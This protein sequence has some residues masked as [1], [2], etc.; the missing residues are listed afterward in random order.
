[1]TTCSNNGTLLAGSPY[2]VASLTL[3]CVY[4]MFTLALGCIACVDMYENPSDDWRCCRRRGAPKPAAGALP[5]DRGRQGYTPV[6]SG[7]PYEIIRTTPG[8][9]VPETRAELCF[10]W[11][12]VLI[13]IFLWIFWGVSFNTEFV[14]GDNTITAQQP[15]N[16][17]LF[18]AMFFGVFGIVCHLLFI[19]DMGQVGNSQELWRS[20]T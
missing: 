14:N 13:F 18:A 20:V 4:I 7:A 15:H 12:L 19:Y 5:R 3:S 8:H 6:P 9:G 2:A 11:G 1:M 10:C 16:E 17:A